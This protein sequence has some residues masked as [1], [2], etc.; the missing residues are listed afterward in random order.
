MN[1][2]KAHR[3]RKNLEQNAANKIAI[4]ITVQ[5]LY[6][7]S[8]KRKKEKFLFYIKTSLQQGL[9]KFLQKR[10]VYIK[11]KNIRSN[12]NE[13]KKK[14]SNETTNE[15]ESIWRITANRITAQRFHNYL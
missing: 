1:D 8:I 6:D 12:N 3:R 4:R 9:I 5:R 15:K 13:K 2:D 11:S 14:N 10:S 7:V